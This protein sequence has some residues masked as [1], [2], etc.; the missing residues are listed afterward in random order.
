MGN[1]IAPFFEPKSITIIGSLRE[2]WFGD[3]IC[4]KHL[5]TFGFSG[6]IYPVSPFY[7]E[8]LDMQVYP[9]IKEVPE[10]VDLAVIDRVISLK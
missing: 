9:S 6:K 2:T 7:S 8:V 1:T 5:L 3:Y 4:L 10:A